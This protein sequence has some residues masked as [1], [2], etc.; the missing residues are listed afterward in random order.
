VISVV[1]MPKPSIAT[2]TMATATMATAI[3]AS[4]SATTIAITTL[5]TVDGIGFSGMVSGSG[6]MAPITIPTTIAGGCVNGPSL[7]GAH[8]GGVAI[9]TA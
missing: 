7:L 6:C 1:A 3:V 2:A 9:T 8:I 4:L 5:T